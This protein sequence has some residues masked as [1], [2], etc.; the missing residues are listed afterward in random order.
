MK[1]VPK[2]R[3]CDEKSAC[4]KEAKRINLDFLYLDLSVCERCQSSSKNLD[5]AIDLLKPII[6]QLR[7][8]IHI[9][10]INVNT[11]ELAHQYKFLSSPTIRINQIDIESDVAEDGCK[12]CGDLCGDSIDCRTF[13][14]QNKQYHEPPVEMIIDE[15]LKSIYQP[16]TIKEPENYQIP[17]NLLKFYQ[18]KNL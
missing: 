3:C 7:Y 15:I 1:I 16:K 14:Y 9:Q 4:C 13:N 17:E 8:S 6:N 2:I 5:I 11:I 18:N 12:S 10:K